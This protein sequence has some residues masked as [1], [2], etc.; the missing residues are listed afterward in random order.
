MPCAVARRRLLGIS[1][2]PC[3]AT[4]ARVVHGRLGL[5]EGHADVGQLGFATPDWL[6]ALFP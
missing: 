6:A 1:E 4:L 3:G 2:Q 5:E